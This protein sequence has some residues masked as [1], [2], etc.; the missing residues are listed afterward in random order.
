VLVGV[1]LKRL[2]RANQVLC[3]THQAQI[4]RHADEH[5]R[6]L[7]QVAGSRTMTT[8]E[9]LNQPGRVEELARMMGG[10]EITAVTKQHAK[11]LLRR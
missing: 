11:E 6:V 4:A 10:A 8:V 5:F 9:R 2:A 7:K 1:R 3:I